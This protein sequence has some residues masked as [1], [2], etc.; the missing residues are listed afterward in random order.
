MSLVRAGKHTAGRGTCCLA[1]V[2]RDTL[3]GHLYASGGWGQGPGL[4]LGPT[5]V[6]V[7]SSGFLTSTELPWTDCNQ[8]APCVCCFCFCYNI[9]SDLQRLSQRCARPEICTKMRHISEEPSGQA[10]SP[11]C[12]DVPG[13]QSCRRVTLPRHVTSLLPTFP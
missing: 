6:T 9:H 8:Q 7:A 10:P 13:Q 11:G 5:R 2:S 4:R 1:E 3:S 12:G